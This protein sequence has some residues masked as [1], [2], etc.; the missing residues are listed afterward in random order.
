MSLQR[1]ARSC[2]VV[3]IIAVLLVLG[4]RK[5]ESGATYAPSLGE[6]M[7]FN[8]IRHARL[9]WAAQA[10]NWPLA[11]H[12]VDELEEGFRDAV[13]FHPTHKSSPVPIAEVI[14]IMTGGPLKVLR[15]AIG[16]KDLGGFTQAFDALT[17]ACNSCHQATNFGFYVVTRPTGNSFLH[18]NFAPP[19][20]EN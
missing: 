7:T 5:E 10:G 4:C 15:D 6:I 14:P 18:Q 3:V 16:K 20:K 2:G 9:W 13:D 17:K 1:C 19:P 11:A 8:Q 12:E